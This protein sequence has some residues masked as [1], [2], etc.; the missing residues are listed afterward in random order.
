MHSCRL[1][2]YCCL[3]GNTDIQVIYCP[4]YTCT[5]NDRTCLC[6]CKSTYNSQNA[7]HA[8]TQNVLDTGG[9]KVKNSIYVYEIQEKTLFYNISLGNTQID[10]S[11]IDRLCT[12]IHDSNSFSPFCWFVQHDPIKQELTEIKFQGQP[13]KIGIS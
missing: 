8:R 7:H 5:A 3:T 13:R 2:I 10:L 4:Q 11:D 1:K 6:R 12:P 9:L